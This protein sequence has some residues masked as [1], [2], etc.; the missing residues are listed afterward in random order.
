MSRRVVIVGMG[1]VAPNAVGLPAFRDALREGRSGIRFFQE[2]ADLK[3]GCQLGATPPLTEAQKG[4]WLTSL[5]QTTLTATGILYGLI[6]GLEAWSHADLPM[7]K[8][9]EAEPDWESGCIFGS[10]IAGAEV[11]RRA[12]YLID[13]GKVKR[14]GSSAVPQVMASGISAYLGGRLGLG[15]QVT[16]NA[17]ACGTGTESLLMGYERV[18]AGSAKRMVCGATDSSGPYVW[19]GFD[20]MRITTRERTALV[21]VANLWS[22]VVR[23]GFLQGLDTELRGQRVR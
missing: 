18:A 11:M 21:G 20:A 14:L 1:V 3:F 13:Q 17:S 16:T 12:T 15:N 23:Q 22:S 5:E 10:G 2:L 8:D 4:R 7:P 19:G 6:A 9:S